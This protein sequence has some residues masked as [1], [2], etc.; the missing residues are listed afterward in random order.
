MA[1]V[2]RG[3][4]IGTSKSERSVPAVPNEAGHPYRTD[5]RLAKDLDF[6]EFAHCEFIQN[7]IDVIRRTFFKERSS[8][9][10][11]RTLRLVQKF[12]LQYNIT[13]PKPI[14]VAKEVDV[15]FCVSFIAY[16]FPF[17][18][19]STLVRFLWRLLRLV[20]VASDIIPPNPY[21]DPL[22]KTREDL[23]ERTARRAINQAKKDALVIKERFTIAENL[24][25]AG[26]DPR[27]VGG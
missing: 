16:C 2:R 15:P 17:K 12:I 24:A 6:S 1:T 21:P 14:T 10:N 8:H 7:N 4:R 11:R 26:S 20:G 18:T 19:R 23:D 25:S 9:Q 22:P 5:A 13:L 3:P 27:R